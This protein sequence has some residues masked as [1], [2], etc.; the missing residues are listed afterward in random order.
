MTPDP[1]RATCSHDDCDGPVRSL[2]LCRK[3][4]RQQRLAKRR[5]EVPATPRPARDLSGPK[6]GSV[7]SKTEVDKDGVKVRVY[8]KSG[9]SAKRP[10]PSYIWTHPYAERE[11]C[12]ACKLGLIPAD[13]LGG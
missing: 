4:Y 6:R 3:H 1:K 10:H 2:G 12:E 13:I 7:V 8:H 11:T 9:T 5:G